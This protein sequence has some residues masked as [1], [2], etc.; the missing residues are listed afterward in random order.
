MRECQLRGTLL[1][2]WDII[3]CVGHYWLR[4]DGRMDGW[5]GERME[6]REDKRRVVA[7]VCNE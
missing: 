1:A 3:G 4:G 6:G 5:V 2:A 7:Q